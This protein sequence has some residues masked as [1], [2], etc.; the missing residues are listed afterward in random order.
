MILGSSLPG[1]LMLNNSHRLFHNLKQ[2]ASQTNISHLKK[3]AAKICINQIKDSINTL[4]YFVSRK[5]TK[6]NISEKNEITI[7]FI[8][9][10]F[11]LKCLGT[12]QFKIWNH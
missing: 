10:N 1:S 5:N 12:I 9:V 4:K 7:N 8:N 11:S 3:N 6:Q 2:F